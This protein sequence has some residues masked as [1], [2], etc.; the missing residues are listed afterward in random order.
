MAFV[1]Y[2][3]GSELN[4][5]AG[6]TCTPLVA[7]GVDH[8]SDGTH[9][10][11]KTIA[12]LGAGN[13]PLDIVPY[14]WNGRASVLVANSRHPLMRMDPGLFADAHSLTN[15]TKEKGVPFVELETPGIVQLADLNDQHVVA[16]QRA[17][18]SLNIISMSK[19]S[20]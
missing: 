18:E 20:L 15:P 2:M 19:G 7:F 8:L 16:L 13:R 9:V 17:G 14:E 1:P 11:G 4:I 6:Y 12:E 10:V 5:L 3:I